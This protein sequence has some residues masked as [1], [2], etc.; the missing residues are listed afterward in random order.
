[1]TS[2]WLMHHEII[3]RRE[4]FFRAHPTCRR[5]S[6]VN[7]IRSILVATAPNEV[8]SFSRCN[9]H[10]PDSEPNRIFWNVPGN[11]FSPRTGSLL[12]S[13]HVKERRISPL[14]NG[15]RFEGKCRKSVIYSQKNNNR[16]RSPMSLTTVMVLP[17]MDHLNNNSLIIRWSATYDSSASIRISMSFSV[18]IDRKENLRSSKFAVDQ[19]TE[20]HT[21]EERSDSHSRIDVLVRRNYISINIC[22]RQWALLLTKKSLSIERGRLLSLLFPIEYISMSHIG[23]L[24]ETRNVLLLT[25]AYA[26]YFYL[27]VLNHARQNGERSVWYQP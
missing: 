27:P 24:G 15:S 3:C 13:M 16:R 17:I 23:F 12:T 18:A 4:I 5:R 8:D 25:M 7:K 26:I 20:K 6:S 9:S 2:V 1:M 19:R 10:H 21:E 22:R 14:S 11:V